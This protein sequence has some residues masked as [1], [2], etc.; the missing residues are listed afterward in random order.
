MKLFRQILTALGIIAVIA[1][2]ASLLPT[3][4]WLVR[5]VDLVREP[6]TYFLAFVFVFAVIL[7]TG[8]RAV[9]A[10]LFGLAIVINLWRIWPY[11]SFAGASLDLAENAPADRC[12]SAMAVNVKLK[13]TQYDKIA[14]QIREY[15]PDVLFLMETDKQW[16]AEMEPLLAEY[17]HVDR[18]PQP[19]AFGL[20]FASRIPVEKSSIVE[21]THRDTPTV[22]ATLRPF[23]DREIEFIGLH[24]KPPLPGWNTQERD[25]NI[26]K[27]GTETPDRL[28]DA[29]VM[30]DFNDVPWSRT[31]SEFR[32]QG[33]WKD[34]RI[35]RG[36]F[37]TFPSRYLLLGWPLDQVMVKGD[38]G[39][40]DFAILP[41]NSSDHRAVLGQFCLPESS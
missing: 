29:V 20:V 31:T 21:N 37:A 38:V 32:E 15:S 6:L 3:D 39:I 8:R 28:P 33:N 19:E 1:T 24:P 22:Y 40:K 35:G 13:N 18:H 10:A 4:W 16:I 5:T 7:P 27:A 9:L 25:R 26:I 12:F 23:G 11:S 41:D 34:P 30:G 36:T 17:P 2:L 14:A